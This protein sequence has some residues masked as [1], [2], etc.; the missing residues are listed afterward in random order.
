MSKHVF[1]SYCTEDE[2]KAFDICAYLERAGIQCWIA[3]R[4]IAPGNS[5]TDAIHTAIEDAAAM[6]VLLSPEANESKFLE[7]E[8]NFAVSDKVPIIPVLLRSVVPSG[9]I[10]FLLD[11]RPL[12]WIDNSEVPWA[13]VLEQL[14][15]ALGSLRNVQ[16]SPKPIAPK[17]AGEGAKGHVFISYSSK[18]LDFVLKVKDILKKRGYWYWDYNESD[19]DY[20][21]A[22]Y[23]ELEK[24]IETAKA[25]LCVVTDSWRESEW[26]ASEYIY[27]KEAGVPVFII[28]A[29]RLSRPVPILLNQQTRI[30][31]AEDFERGAAILEHELDKKGL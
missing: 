25:F 16:P 28:L 27:A 8:V 20:H 2:E 18:D 7:F 14:A 29:K 13:V 31:M 1:I 22:L 24:R 5:F 17:A 12:Q 19:R 26:P 30:D 21:G 9:R 6:V 23:R 3:P 11:V 4:D 10:R 15:A